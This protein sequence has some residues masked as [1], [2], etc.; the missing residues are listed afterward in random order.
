MIPSAPV[1]YC[2]CAYAEVVP[3]DVR[4]AVLAA[5]AR[6]GADLAAV[7]DLCELAARH[8]EGLARLA[9]SP[10]LTVIACHPRAVRWLFDAAGSPLRP[11][12]TILD[13]RS[14][15]ADAIL[16]Q[17]A[18]HLDGPVFDGRHATAAAPNSNAPL[19]ESRL[20]AA[21]AE[22]RRAMNEDAPAAAPLPAFPA[23][24]PGGW[25][26]WFP[27]LDYDRCT[28]CGQCVE[29][30]LFGVYKA[31]DPARAG[32]P[33][34]VQPAKCKTNCPA[35]ARVCPASAIIFPKYADGPISGEDGVLSAPGEA[36]AQADLAALGGPDA[37]EAL[38]RRA[39]KARAA[40][41]AKRAGG[42][43]AP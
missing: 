26:P 33:R 28:G 25:I 10:G 9:Q 22:T 23:K 27:V 37:F 7:A 17:L 4:D 20:N 35:C 6:S 43:P 14:L 30:C 32:K 21:G 13:M 8:D 38:R 29:F 34:V 39:A 15:T 1:L 41:E 5:L 12:A 3:A 24:P 18:A 42:H 2:R 16:S 40:A 11:D 36:A 31:S 19:A